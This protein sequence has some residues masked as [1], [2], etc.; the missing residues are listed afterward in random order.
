MDKA[1]REDREAKAVLD[2]EVKEVREDREA[3]DKEAKEA[4]AALDKK[5]KEVK[6]T[7]EAV[8]KEAR[9]VRKVNLVQVVKRFENYILNFVFILKLIRKN[10][11]KCCVYFFSQIFVKKRN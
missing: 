3:V 4:K 11:A 5:V 8:D 7:R 1:A 9:E 6:E 10:L 2:K